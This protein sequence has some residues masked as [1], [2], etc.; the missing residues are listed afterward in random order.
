MELVAANPTVTAKLGTPLVAAPGPIN[1]NISLDD[2]EGEGEGDLR[3]TLRGP[4]GSAHVRVEAD[5]NDGVW[6]LESVD[7]E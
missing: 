7:L 4:K 6:T 1:G 2:G 3:F 5:R